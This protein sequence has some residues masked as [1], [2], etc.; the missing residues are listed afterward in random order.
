MATAEKQKKCLTVG[1]LRKFL[2]GIPDKI[3]IRGGFDEGIEAFLWVAKP[4]E[5]GPKKY[6]PLK[7]YLNDPTLQP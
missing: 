3:P 2:D 4:K 1:A 6:I 5:S 7:R